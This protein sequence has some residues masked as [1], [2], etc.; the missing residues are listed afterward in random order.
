[1]SKEARNYLRDGRA[2]VPL[3]GSTSR[4]M[5]ANKAKDT[6]PELIFRKA[7]LSAGIKGYRLNWKKAPGRPDIAFPGRKL[8]IFINGC[9]WHRCEKC[10]P[11]LPKSN[12]DFW[13]QK[14]IKNK[15]R[16]ERKNQELR[17]LG[18]TVITIWECDI[19][20]SLSTTVEMVKNKF[21]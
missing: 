7:L 19:K 13:T 14:F 6:N 5:S 11:N 8:A 4:V 3:K 15:E 12:V 18:W 9:F 17:L 21:L 1:M 20:N 10:H 16:D 2:P